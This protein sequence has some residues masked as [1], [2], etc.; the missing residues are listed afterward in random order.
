MR[1]ILEHLTANDEIAIVGAGQSNRLPN[2]D[3]DTEGFVAAP[4]LALRA[5]GMDLTILA[6]VTNTNGTQ[7]AIGSKSAVSV[8]EAMAANDWVN[9]EVR[10]IQHEFGDSVLSGASTA[11][12]L[13]V[14]HA[15]VRSNTAVAS[16]TNGVLLAFDATNNRVQ[17]LSHGR[18]AGSQVVFA[19]GTLPTAIAALPA[20]TPLY[21]HSPTEHAF[22]VSLLPP[23]HAVALALSG[24]SGAVVCTA[25]A[26]LVVEW[27]SVLQAAVAGVTNTVANPAVFTQAA[28]GYPEHS[29]LVLSVSPTGFPVAGTV[30]FVV[31]P[32]VNEYKLALTPG[33]TPIEATAG[34]GPATVTPHAIAGVTGYVHLHDRYKAYDNVQ[35][36]TPFQPI[37]P[38]PYPDVAA[39]TFAP[40]YTFDSD[41]TQGSDVALVLPYTW[42]EGVD[43]YGA[44]GTCTIASLVVTLTGGLTV[45]AGLFAGGFVRAGGAKGRIVS[46]TTTTVTVA[47]WVGTPGSGTQN[48]LLWL[49]HWRNNPH[50][51]IAGEGFMYP[52][53]TMQPGGNSVGTNGY[54]YS[55]PRARL[56]GSYVFR[57]L[58]SASVGTAINSSGV[59]R[60]KTTGSGQ[61]VPVVLTISPYPALLYLPLTVST[62]DPATELIQHNTVFRPG[63]IVRLAGFGQTPSIDGDWRVVVLGQLG[64]G[65][66]WSIGLEPLDAT[67]TP[68]PGSVSGTVAANATITR[69][70]YKRVYKFGSLIEC[71]HRMAVSLGRRLVVAHL[72]VNAAGMSAVTTG[73]VAGYQ[74]QLGWWDDDL[75]HDWTPSNPDGLAVRLKRLVEFIA[76]RAVRATFGSTKTLKVLAIDFWGA[77]T[78]TLSAV[79]RELAQRSI[80]AF[81][82]WLRALIVAAGLSPYPAQAKIPLHWAKITSQPW[83]SVIVGDTTGAVKA[84]IVRMVAFDEGFTVAIDPD[85]E[86][87]LA[88]TI[89][90]NGVGEAHNGKNAAAALLPVMD[91][92]FQFQLGPG[93]V[94]VANQALSLIGEA[95][96]VTALEPPNATVQARLC[97]QFMEEAR[98]QVLQSHPWTFATRRCTPTSVTNTVSTWAYAYAVPA[99][100]LHPTAILASDSP[101][102]LQIRAT[103]FED[104][105]A[106]PVSGQLTNASAKFRLET[107]QEGHRVLR[108]TQEAPV[109]VYTA[110]NVPFELWD[111]LARQACAFRL[112]H[113]LVGATLKTKLGAALAQQMLQMS[114]ALVARAA[115]Q[116]VEYQQD[117]QVQRTCP[118][119]P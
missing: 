32:T 61:I 63:Y 55:R 70:Y 76:P 15:I 34:T 54:T 12:T 41:V 83:E 40:G 80:P 75:H 29:S 24:A 1:S 113:L 82:D 14:G 17:W 46:N 6:I 25:R 2:G 9:G 89:H 74:G 67:L 90:F 85:A 19:G 91:Y 50:H 52:S 10:L 48:V 114:E 78:D 105:I 118:W 11:T 84:A 51:Y 110:K 103:K 95:A 58:A 97:A 86:P 23:P 5:A 27:Q 59:A 45:T 116:N 56:T 57:S 38:G 102:D 36:V 62:S 81:A 92:A 37:E 115:A 22:Q 47:A 93:A 99:D 101:D 72:G 28:H 21:V 43:G 106:L 65:L 77:E 18:P 73:N 112:A 88:D 66:G 39:Y 8:A 35:V 100:M 98:S 71:A 111:P 42:E 104:P 20:G 64:P 108:T 49:P 68:L 33:G 96:N 44:S 4:H 3:R 107:D 13:R 119:L 7:G 31:A 94:A 60:V 109:V 30:L 16:A 117:V 69:L 87:K 26:C 53:S 79:G